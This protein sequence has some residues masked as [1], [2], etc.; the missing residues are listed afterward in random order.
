[1]Q[2]Q[3]I[4]APAH[5]F[6]DDTI[7]AATDRQSAIVKTCANIHENKLYDEPVSNCMAVW[8]ESV[9][10]T[11]LTGPWGLG[12][13]PVP[14][15]RRDRPLH[16]PSAVNRSEAL[17]LLL[18]GESVASGG[19]R[20]LASPAHP[21]GSAVLPSRATSETAS[22]NLVSLTPHQ[23]FRCC[24]GQGGSSAPRVAPRRFTSTRRPPHQYFRCSTGRGS[25]PAV[26]SELTRLVGSR[27]DIQVDVH[28]SLDE[29]LAER[30]GAA[31]LDVVVVDCVALGRGTRATGRLPD[32]GA[33]KPT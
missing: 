28:A 3:S 5:P 31:S 18:A 13:E 32:V 1:M 12:V 33:G 23:E 25:A 9:R 29:Y 30:S 10:A 19:C 2:T 7:G 20:G 17:S 27:S 11:G 14:V 15:R 26:R 8:V 4:E 6:S 21:T 16:R 22:N 24:S